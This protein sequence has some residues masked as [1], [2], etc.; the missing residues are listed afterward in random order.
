M[1]REL[2]V[3]ET[4]WV[5]RGRVG[6]DPGNYPVPFA[7]G[8]ITEVVRRSVR[9]D[10]PGGVIVLIAASA[11]HRDIGILSIKVGDFVSEATLLDPLAKSV[12]QFCRLLLPDDWV[13][14][15]SVRSVTECRKAWTLNHGVA[16][17][18][19]LSGHGGPDS[20]VFGVD[21]PIGGQ[22]LGDE[23]DQA[24]PG[25]TPKIFISLGCMTGQAAFARPFS[26]AQTCA[27]FLA[28]FHSVHGAVASQFA[29]TFLIYYLLEGKSLGV[30]FKH[31]R[32]RVA[33]ATSF[34]MWVNGTQTDG[35]R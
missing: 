13:R 3:G 14:L 26:M 23:L 21:G 2:R 35:P 10:L 33:G 4:V 18:V 12:G 22:T 32:T 1:A 31:A 6:M 29:Q 17:V 11:V 30:A 25:C 20:F 19:I 15:L 8:T 9:V 27:A 16:T 5:P 24:V 34:R 28:P 7:Q